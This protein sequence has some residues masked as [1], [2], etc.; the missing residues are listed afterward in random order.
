MNRVKNVVVVMAMAVALAAQGCGGGA[1]ETTTDGP[2]GADGALLFED[3]YSQTGVIRVHD[4]GG[5]LSV[6]VVGGIGTDD[7][8]A[9]GQLLA[10]EE[11]SHVYLKL[12][13]E[14]QSAPEQL[15]AIDTRLERE[16]AAEI[17][18]SAA[19]RASEEH[20]VPVIDKSRS[21]FLSN[22]CQ[23]FGT[24]FDAWIPDLC[25]YT[26]AT[27]IVQSDCTKAACASQWIHRAGDR[28]FM[29]NENTRQ[30]L[31]G[32]YDVNSQ[33]GLDLYRVGSLPAQTW[34][35]YSNNFDL[36]NYGMQMERDVAF[37]GVTHHWHKV[38]PR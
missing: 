30:A 33:G 16:R 5:H 7:H 21:S 3:H 22:A 9:M 18:T 8:L 24:W 25:R 27:G 32:F 19:E 1:A 38:I 2:L 14:A 11:L 6:Q 17:A 31:V 12:H 34:G 36:V 28:A 15:M 26:E 13:P 20:A 29:W 35:Y 10:S 4:L 23:T 37:L